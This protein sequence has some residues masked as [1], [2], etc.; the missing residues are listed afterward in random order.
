LFFV[1]IRIAINPVKTQ[2]FILLFS[3]I[4]CGLK[5]YHDI[6]YENKSVRK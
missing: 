4:Y 1:T 6:E 2:Q 5:G 3:T